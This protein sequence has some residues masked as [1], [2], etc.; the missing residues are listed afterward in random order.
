M[1]AIHVLGAM[2]SVAHQLRR[3]WRRHEAWRVLSQLDRDQLKDIGLD[4]GDAWS[5]AEAYGEH[6]DYV[7]KGQFVE[8]SR[9]QPC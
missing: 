7:C 9:G 4:T 1:L 2:R 8:Q 5:A 6:R 3:A